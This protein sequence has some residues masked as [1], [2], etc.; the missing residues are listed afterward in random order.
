MGRFP[1]TLYQEQ[2]NTLLDHAD[3]IRELAVA[4]MNG[5]FAQVAG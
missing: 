3:E 4:D 2:W 1:V 5:L